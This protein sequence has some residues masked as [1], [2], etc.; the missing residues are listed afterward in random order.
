V[1]ETQRL[2]KHSTYL[3]T[4]KASLLYTEEIPLEPIKLNESSRI[5][6]QFFWIK[7]T[8]VKGLEGDQKLSGY[9]Y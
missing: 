6:K 3:R 9:N 7:D 8:I 4:A 2:P 1:V 5:Q